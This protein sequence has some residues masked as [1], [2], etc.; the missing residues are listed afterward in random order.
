MAQILS[1]AADLR[2]RAA[3]LLFALAILAA[4]L[5]GGGYVN[6]SYVTRV[7]WT[8]HQPVP[9]SH[10]HHVGDDGIDCRYCHDKV[11]VSA[12][13]GYPPTHTCMTCHSQLF[14]GA[15]VLAPV[16]QSFA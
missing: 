4:S 1:A 14:A 5:V 7:G 9:F 8:Q 2:L 11:E 3:A 6:S 15:P 10:K 16:R 13:A 12:E